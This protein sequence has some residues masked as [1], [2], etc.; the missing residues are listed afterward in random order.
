MALFQRKTSARRRVVV[1]LSDLHS[2]HKLGL[3]NPD[4]ILWDE[5]Q[6]G[7][8]KARPISLGA[9]QEYLWALYQEHIEGVTEFAAGD[10]IVVLHNGDL[11]QGT[12]YPDQVASNELDDQ[13]QTGLWNL[14]PWFALPNVKTVRLLLGT[15]VHTLNGS[16]ELIIARLLRSEYG[17]RSVKAISHGLFDIDGALFDVAHHGANASS[18]VWLQGNQLRYY[19]RSLMLEELLA[20]NRP[21]DVVLRSHFHHWLPPETVSVGAGGKVY[22]SRMM[23]TSS[24]C[25]M[26]GHAR[27]ATR[28]QHV[29][30]HGLVA[31]EIIGGEVCR[32][33][34]FV[35][36]LDLRTKET[37]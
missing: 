29:Q 11:T 10:E 35:K 14:K 12:H 36:T 16:S 34:P 28:S 22:T 25:G 5:D 20:G 21:P 37:L 18:R 27:K 1:C 8:P 17:D 6:E 19:L 23:L 30:N 3:A 9:T 13:I 32:V 15:G 4:T 26:G 31:I 7:N 33:K 24:Y 2:G